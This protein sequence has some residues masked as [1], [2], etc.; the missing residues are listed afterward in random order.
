MEAATTLL[1]IVAIA[2]LIVQQHLHSRALERQRQQ[3]ADLV[4]DL[5]SRIVRPAAPVP[6]VQRAAVATS[7][8]PREHPEALRVGEV[9]PPAKED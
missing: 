2:A 7:P 4:N 6:S 8:E 5:A 3:Y 1:A 9:A